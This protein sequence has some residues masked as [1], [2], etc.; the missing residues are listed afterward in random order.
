VKILAEN[1]ADLNVVDINKKL[2]L[3]YAEDKIKAQPNEKVFQEIKEYLVS[4][5]AQNSWKY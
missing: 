3:N 4:K 1:N 2:P 5:G